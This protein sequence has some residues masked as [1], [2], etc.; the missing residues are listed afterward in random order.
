MFLERRAVP[1]H[2]GWIPS[3]FN[4]SGF[5]QKELKLSMKPTLLL[6]HHFDCHRLRSEILLTI[7]SPLLIVTT[8]RRLGRN[9][10]DPEPWIEQLVLNYETAIPPDKAVKATVIGVKDLTESQDE[11]DASCVLYLSDGVVH[12]P[13][14]LTTQAWS[15]LQDMEERESYSGLENA[16]VCVKN[17][18]LNFHMEP[19]RDNCQFYVTVNQISTIGQGSSHN[20]VPNCATLPSIKEQIRKTWRSRTDESSSQSQSILRLTDLLDAWVTDGGTQVTP[21]EVI[22][23]PTPLPGPTPARHN[24]GFPTPPGPTHS[25]KNTP[26]VSC[27]SFRNMYAPTQATPSHCTVDSPAEPSSSHHHCVAPPTSGQRPQSLDDGSKLA[28]IRKIMSRLAHPTLP[29]SNDDVTAPTQWHQD[30]LS[31]KGEECFSVPGYHLLRERIATATAASTSRSPPSSLVPPLSDK[32]VDQPTTTQNEGPDQLPSS[33]E[34]V[35]D[36]PRSS[37]LSATPEDMQILQSQSA[38]V[39]PENLPLLQSQSATAQNLPLIEPQSDSATPENLPVTKVPSDSDT[40]EDGLLTKIQSDSATPEN[41]PLIQSQS[42]SATPRKL[43]LLHGLTSLCTPENLRHL[44]SQLGST[45][46]EQFP[47]HQSLLARL[48][49][50]PIGS[51]TQNVSSNG[52][53]AQKTGSTLPPYQPQLP[54]VIS[55]S[56]LSGK[57]STPRP[58]PEE[59]DDTKAPRSPPSW[60]AQTQQ[61]GSNH[62]EVASQPKRRMFASPS[63]QSWVHKDGSAFYYKY[64]ASVQDMCALGRFTVPPEMIQ[65]SVRY[66]LA[67]ASPH[68]SAE[69]PG[70]RTEA[71]EP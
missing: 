34:R 18:Q 49:S 5:P 25:R 54:L 19:E 2:V 15:R 68:T 48:S 63:E 33:G 61:T 64:Q 38:S 37:R 14:V 6:A 52:S 29:L 66:L 70:Q 62:N 71:P 43:P 53:R 39:L 23:R 60:I 16:I 10:T 45:S 30:R 31:Y 59:E 8:M 65:W 35:D 11:T 47:L 46:P 41:L 9:H 51:S 26:P 67:S 1:S 56:Q 42:A 22:D 36:S 13:A 17:L 12:I 3:L 28:L 69:E 50:A 7:S 32:Q 40:T 57:R 27:S 20:A 21:Q 55:P 4:S 44:D 58:S 24:K